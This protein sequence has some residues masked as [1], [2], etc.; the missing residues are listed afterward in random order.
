MK[1]ALISLAVL[2]FALIGVAQAANLCCH[3]GAACC[4]PGA[5]C[6]K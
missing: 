3:S 5:A 6:C 4:T 1:K 2:A